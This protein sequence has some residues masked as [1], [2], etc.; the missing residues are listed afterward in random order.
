MIQMFGPQWSEK[1]CDKNGKNEA[2]E[3]ALKDLEYAQI[4][5]GLSK[6]RNGAIKFYEIDLPRF[7]EL[8][9]PPPKPMSLGEIERPKWTDGMSEAEMLMH[10]YANQKMFV[11]YWRHP[12]VGQHGTKELSKDQ[13]KALWHASRRIAHDFFLMREELGKENVPDEDFLK[14]LQRAWSK[15]IDVV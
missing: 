3:D 4:S 7:L 5:A 8:C 2:W 12:K 1:F 14:A 13:N 10:F 9:R 6:V 11:F 15:I